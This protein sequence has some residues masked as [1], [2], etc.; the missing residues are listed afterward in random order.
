MSYLATQPQLMAAAAE[1]LAGIG[2]AVADANASVVGSTTSMAAA[3]AD[4]VSAAAAQLFGAFGREYQQIAAQASAFGDHLGRTL[5]SAGAA[6]AESELLG[7]AALGGTGSAPRAAP[8]APYDIALIMSGTGTTTPPSWFIDVVRPY[9]QF[10]L[11]A[12][13]SVVPL[14]TPEQFYPLAG[15]MPLS[16]SVSRG[17]EI[18]HN[19]IT[20]YLADGK[21][22]TVLGYSQSSVIASLELRQLMA[23]GS[24]QTNQ[25]S[26]TL[27]A[28]P[29]NPNGGLLSRFAG[30]SFPALGFD[31]YGATPANSGYPVNT[32]TVQYDGWASFPRYPL[33]FLA[34]LNAIMGMQF[35]HGFYASVDPNALPP[36]VSIVEQQVSPTTQANGLDRYYMITYPGL[37]L[38]LPL[39]FLLPIIGNPL[40]DLIQPNLTYLVNLGYGDP[41]YG[42][43]T[44]YADVPTP[45]GLFPPIPATFLSDQLALAQQGGTAFA[46]YFGGVP[47][48]PLPP[49]ANPLASTG[50]P[51]LP[52]QVGLPPDVVASMDRFIDD[53]KFVNTT[54]AT[55]ISSTAS[56]VYGP[57]PPADLL[58]TLLVTMPSYNIDLFLD[59]LQ[60]AINGDPMGLVEAIGKPIAAN[61]ALGMF[62][63]FLGFG[64]TLNL[65]GAVLSLLAGA[66]GG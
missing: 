10:P 8:A 1:Q 14:T 7:T 3:A 45:F 6:Y 43:S 37:P 38:L 35:V 46:S 26:F 64:V 33:N 18:L 54:T 5:T 48:L 15:F 30:L 56:E 27:L 25:L 11:K 17:V 13:G 23:M 42:Y 47:E 22:V 36:G 31:F 32:Y 2:T 19:A 63:G 50:A 62:T 39:R 59:G 41:N 12:T 16:A 51:G 66:A 24:P 61:M 28:N 4:E 29:M 53:L 57:I 65:L 58:N 55:A 60:Q 34:D 9:I 44:S 40:A 49:I 20:G 21:S 52:L